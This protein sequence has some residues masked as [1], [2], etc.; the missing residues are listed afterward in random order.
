MAVFIF[1]DCVKVCFDGICV[2][3]FAIRKCYAWT[4]VECIYFTV[5]T[6][7]P[8]FCQTAFKTVRGNIDQALI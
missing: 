7:I 2:T 3:L 1:Q 6:D 5:I 8:A 4:N